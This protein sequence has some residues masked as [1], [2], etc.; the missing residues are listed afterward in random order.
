MR[1][2]IQGM[3]GP[4]GL[5]Q[6]RETGAD[7]SLGYLKSLTG[8]LGLYDAMSRVSPPPTMGGR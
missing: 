6:A 2:F 1:H 8:I 7:K 4:E 3:V 5:P